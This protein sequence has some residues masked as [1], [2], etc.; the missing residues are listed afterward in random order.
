MVFVGGLLF[1][2]GGEV[3]VYLEVG[4]DGEVSAESLE[5]FVFGFSVVVDEAAG[6]EAEDAIGEELERIVSVDQI[7]FKLY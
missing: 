6:A 3:G 7:A 2:V 4:L 5:G 1:G